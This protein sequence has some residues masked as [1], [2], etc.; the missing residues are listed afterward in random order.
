MDNDNRF[1]KELVK[2]YRKTK[3]RMDYRGMNFL[4][5]EIGNERICELI[6]SKTPF[7][8]AR[9]GAVEMHLVAKWMKKEAYS[10]EE[11]E[12][13]LFA[14]GIFPNNS[15]MLDRFCMTYI[16][17][18]PLCDLL[19]VWEVPGEK[20]AIQAYCK[21]PVLAPIRSLEPYYF[22][23]PWSTALSGK[24]VLVIH[25]F[26][27]SIQSQYKRRQAVWPEKVV[28]PEFASI[29]YVK[30]VQSNAGGK[31][32]FDDWFCALEDMKEKMGKSEFD[33]AIIGAGAYG[34]PLAA[35]AKKLGK[36]AIQMSGA[37]QILFGIKGK[38]WDN[39]PVISGFYNDSWIRPSEQ[40]TPPQTDKVEGGSYW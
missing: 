19:G 11:R 1:K 7:M 24:K 32:E 16:E 39:H 3:L 4:S 33:I 29:S 17:A 36:S 27:E 22:E 38:R 2:I 20:M 40:E 6:Q 37:T 9:F 18:M 14:A 34:F 25:P 28:L 35:H 12:Q 26:T 13:A 31:V 8:V 15:H 23:N 10:F 30:A 21:K 5:E